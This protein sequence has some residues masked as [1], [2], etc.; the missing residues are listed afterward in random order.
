MGSRSSI[1]SAFSGFRGVGSRVELS[2]APKAIWNF[3][4]DSLG[5]RSGG[6]DLRKR[7]VFASL[8]QNQA[9]R[10]RFPKEARTVGAFDRHESSDSFDFQGSYAGLFKLRGDPFAGSLGR[11]RSGS[12][13]TRAARRK[14][15]W[16]STSL[17]LGPIEMAQR[18]VCA[19]DRSGGMTSPCSRKAE[20]D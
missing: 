16:I 17:G 10:E 11:S 20:C 6:D 2:C 13:I 5:R 7:A 14:S 9:W 4:L 19:F 15:V 1:C 18:L 12:S 8:V 3:E